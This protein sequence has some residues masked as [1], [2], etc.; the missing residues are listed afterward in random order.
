MSK[1]R[2]HLMTHCGYNAGHPWYY[3]LGGAIPTPKQIQAEARLEGYRGYAKDDIEKID[4]MKEPQRSE[5]LRQMKSKF[6]KDLRRDLSWHRRL[7]R[8]L[9]RY[10]CEHPLTER[11]T[12]C[13]EIHTSMGL[14]HSH[15]F[16]D[17]G[18]LIYLDELLSKQG[19]LFG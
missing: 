2:Q 1:E 5:Q 12:V 13:A 7:V 4:Q 16:N 17:F 6:M 18:H 15:L 3:L 19:D 9:R 8:E 11:P 10:Q 14:N